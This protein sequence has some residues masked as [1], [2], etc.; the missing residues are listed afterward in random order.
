MQRTLTPLQRDLVEEFGNIY[1]RYGLARLKGL[2]VGLLL[3]QA[4]PLSLDEIATMLNRS[5]GPISSTIRELASIG[6][7]RKVNGPE[8]RRDYYVAHPDLFL[9][10]FK[11]NLATVRKNRRTAEQFLRE[12]EATGESTY[13]AALGRLRH[14]EA[15]YR[16]MEQFYESFTQEWEQVQASLEEAARTP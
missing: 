13:H 6:L 10:N 8:N 4:D 12:M 16:L 15:F 5:K 3:T 11:F 14:M 2:I 1:E 7:V 9:N